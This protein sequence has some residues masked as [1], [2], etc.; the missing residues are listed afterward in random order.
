MPT[1]SAREQHFSILKKYTI[2][3]DR[4]FL[5]KINIRNDKNDFKNL[6]KYQQGTLARKIWEIFRNT[7]FKLIVNFWG[8]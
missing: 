8:K 3:G 5:E 6:H 4:T 1:G 2:L 7:Q